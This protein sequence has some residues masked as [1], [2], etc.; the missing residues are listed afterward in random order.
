MKPVSTLSCPPTSSLRREKRL[1]KPG[2][3]RA[4]VM[5]FFQRTL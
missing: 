2:K 3:E 4:E 5:R 1:E